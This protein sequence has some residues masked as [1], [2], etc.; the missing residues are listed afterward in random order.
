MADLNKSWA[1]NR[2]HVLRDLG[3]SLALPLRDCMKPLLRAEQAKRPR[4][5]VFIICPAGAIRTNIN[6]DGR[7]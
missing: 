4:Y 2:R 3:V 7:G 6:A 5:S 1:L